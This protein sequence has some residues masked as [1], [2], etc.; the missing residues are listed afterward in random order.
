MILLLLLLLLL[1][2]FFNFFEFS[3]VFVVLIVAFAVLFKLFVFCGCLYCRFQS[4]KSDIGWCIVRQR[5][6]VAPGKCVYVFE[7]NFL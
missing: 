3:D 4:C 5:R 1:L 7:C 6:F 2:F